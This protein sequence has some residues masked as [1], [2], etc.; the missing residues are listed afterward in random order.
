M[1][2]NRKYKNIKVISLLMF[3]EKD[4]SCRYRVYQFK[5]YLKKHDILLNAYSVYSSRLYNLR[6]T[7]PQ[8]NFR[9]LIMLSIGLIKR[10][11]IQLLTSFRYNI[12]FV[13]RQ[14]L[15]GGSLVIEKILKKMGKKIIYDFDDAIF[16]PSD[17]KNGWNTIK[18]H[19]KI[20]DLIIVGNSYL[21][22]Y[23]KK[24]NKNVYIVPS[25]IDIKKYKIK[26]DYSI[27]SNLK[28]GWIGSPSTA[29]FIE[30][31]RGVLYKLSK[32]IKFELILIGGK[33]ELDG[34]NTKYIEWSEE[35]EVSELPGFD[36]GISPLPDNEWTR[37]KCGVKLLQYMTVGLPTVSSPVGV[38]KDIIQ[39]GVNG[40]LAHDNNEWY[41]I[42][43]KLINDQDLRERI[44]KQARNTIENKYNLEKA[45]NELANLIKGL[46]HE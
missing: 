3:P 14:T 32:E 45:S 36:I 18:E 10:C 13:H 41:E 15:P 37:G 35:N 30:N 29:K 24:Y 20:A 22:D 2:P 43:K 33:I 16:I 21:A 7:H 8:W 23:A 12:I 5:E 38:H 25:V 4:P 44:G 19:I 46:Y 40:F 11:S 9:Q 1:L 27:K 42:I 39:N 17:S 28:I 31:I 6:Q 34:I 26:N